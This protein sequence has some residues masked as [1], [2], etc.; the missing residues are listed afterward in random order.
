VLCQELLGASVELGSVRSSVPSPILDLA[1]PG[2]AVRIVADRS[3]A[4]IT[5]KSVAT[6]SVEAGRQ[7]VVQ[8]EPGADPDTA[9]MWLHGSVAALLLGQQG[10]F[11]LHASVADIGGAGVAIAG[12][13]GVGKSTTWMR[14][15]Q[16]GHAL[17]TDDVSPLDVGADTVSVV[18][19]GRAPHL[20]PATAETLAIDVSAARPVIL[21]RDKLALP[22][23]SAQ[24]IGL[25]AVAVLSVNGDDG[26]HVERARGMT[27]LQLV[28]ANAY[29]GG[30]LRLLWRRELFAWAGAV[31]GLAPVHVLTRPRDGWSADSVAVAVEQVAASTVGAR[32]LNGRR[33]CEPGR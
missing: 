2:A 6:Y 8:L 18:P 20:Y 22:P 1:P 19:F 4:V 9:T 27:A 25:S 24:P 21:G 7:V 23:P 26:L 32:R 3:R 14:L 29:R 10:R 13:V 11:A 15:A 17:V 16:R 28:E 5:V 33:G 31:A 12:P 30:L